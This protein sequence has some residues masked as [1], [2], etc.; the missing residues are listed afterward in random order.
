MDDHENMR[1]SDADRQETVERLRIALDDGR[2]KLEEY[3]ERM[4]HAYEAVTYGD[5]GPLTADLPKTR[6]VAKPSQPAPPAPAHAAPAP[7]RPAEV[8]RSGWFAGLPK[9]LKIAWTAWTIAVSVNVVVW[10]LVCITATSFIYPWPLWV[11]GP[12]GAVLL[13][14]SATTSASRRG[15][16]P[17]PHPLP[18]GQG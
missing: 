14:I 1:A 9:P 17:P 12:W 6:S 5:L 2:L 18:P 3:L 11:A 4:G 16:Q 15:R 13:A 7:A 10:V 8:D